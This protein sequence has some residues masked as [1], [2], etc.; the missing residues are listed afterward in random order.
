[1]FVKYDFSSLDSE[2]IIEEKRGLMRT[3]SMLCERC[4]RGCSWV[5]EWTF[6]NRRTF[7]DSRAR[8]ILKEGPG[9]GGV[10][11]QAVTMEEIPLKGKQTLS[12]WP[13]RI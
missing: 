8:M 3:D 4:L 5:S 10:M 12:P 7:G 6:S 9:V 2:M 11:P 13:C 1:V